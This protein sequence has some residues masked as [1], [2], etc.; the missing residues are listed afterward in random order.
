MNGLLLPDPPGLGVWAL[1]GALR[2]HSTE[3]L[4]TH[5]SH[6]LLTIRSGVSLLEESARQRPLFGDLC[7]FIPSGCPHRT[8]VVGHPIA[9]QSLYFQPGPGEAL[10]GGVTLF[11]FGALGD[12]LF[13]RLQARTFEDLSEG[14]PGECF[15]LLQQVMREDLGAVPG[16]ITLPLAKLRASRLVVRFITAHFSQPLR[17]FHF[18]KLLN[19]SERHVARLFKR[20]T[21]ITILDYLRA[22]R[23][24][25]AAVLLHEQQPSIT[26]VAA[27]CGYESLSCFYADFTRYFAMTPVVL[28]RLLATPVPVSQ[29]KG[30]RERRC[31]GV[32][33]NSS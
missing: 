25:Q 32:S 26:D 11:R 3:R 24:F 21:G 30:R 5:P 16:A 15:R 33:A 31:Q 18:A 23:M 19:C 17:L 20:D 9:Y 2:E 7:A 22:Y 6:Q 28:R 12:A 27:A 29:V 14:L 4:H 1:N 13:Q 10:P 8:V